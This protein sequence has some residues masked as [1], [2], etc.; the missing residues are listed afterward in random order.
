MP[1]ESYEVHGT[2]VLACTA[3]GKKLQ[4][5]RDAVELIG[6]ALQTGASVVAIPVERF[7]DDFFRLRTR[8]AGEIVQKFVQYRR[9]LAIIGDISKYVAESSAFAAFVH[10]ANRGEDIWFVSDLAELAKRLVRRAT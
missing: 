1:Q 6:E 3:D 10:E 5:D 8:I 4:N 7:E 9:R 2:R